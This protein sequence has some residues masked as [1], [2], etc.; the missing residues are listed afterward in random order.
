MGWLK[1]KLFG[2]SL[3]KTNPRRLGFECGAA[4][5]RQ[6]VERIGAGFVEGYR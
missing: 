6:R 2:I 3:E 5:V 4:S 1:K